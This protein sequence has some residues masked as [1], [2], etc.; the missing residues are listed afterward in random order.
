MM[1]GDRVEA[2][3]F[4]NEVR[5]R[6][7][8]PGYDLTISADELSVDLI[9]DE[10]GRELAGEMHRWFDLIRSGK[11]LERIKAHSARGQS[12]QSF[13]LLRPIPQAEID[14]AN[15]EVAQNIGY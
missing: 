2:T 4:F 7:Q 14:R 11:A 10:R 9:L 1:Q 3:W 15:N 13:H 5:R 6:A 8:R 12:I